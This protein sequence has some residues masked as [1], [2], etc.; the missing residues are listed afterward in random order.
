MSVGEV[1]SLVLLV[2]LMLGVWLRVEDLDGVVDRLGCLFSF[3][4]MFVGNCFLIE[5]LL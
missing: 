3:L 2:I 5:V 1:V 4:L